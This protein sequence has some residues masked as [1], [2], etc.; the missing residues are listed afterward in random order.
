[1]SGAHD[2]VRI[3]LTLVHSCHREPIQVSPVRQQTFSSP[4]CVYVRNFTVNGFFSC[5]PSE[6]ILNFSDWD[7]YLGQPEHITLQ[8]LKNLG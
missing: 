8:T 3:L 1:M 7:S 4:D 5:D 6:W 2:G